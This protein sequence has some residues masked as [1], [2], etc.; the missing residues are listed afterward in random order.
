MKTC[1]SCGYLIKD[2]DGMVMDDE[3]R[4]YHH[5]CVPNF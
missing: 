2:E 4:Y 1:E 3:G 5:D